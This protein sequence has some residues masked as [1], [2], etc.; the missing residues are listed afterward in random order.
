M[1]PFE[2]KYTKDINGRKYANISG[3]LGNLQSIL[4]TGSPLIP[5]NTV[6]QNPLPAYTDPGVNAGV[7]QVAGNQTLSPA[8]LAAAGTTTT[9]GMSNT[10]KYLLIALAAGGIGFLIYKK[11][12][13]KK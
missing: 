9:T 7:T 3:T 11:L 13:A 4:T 6:T 5:D 2:V 1:D 10:V 12:K 8:Q